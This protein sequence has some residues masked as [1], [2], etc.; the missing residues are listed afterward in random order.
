M[1]EIRETFT[2]KGDGLLDNLEMG[3]LDTE[4]AAAVVERWPGKL[5]ALA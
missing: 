5:A 3:G 2:C 4:A 1:E